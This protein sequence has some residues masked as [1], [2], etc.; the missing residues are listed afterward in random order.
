MQKTVFDAE[1]VVAARFGLSEPVHHA[2]VSDQTITVNGGNLPIRVYRPDNS[3]ASYPGI[4]YFHDGGWVMGN[5]ITYDASARAIAEQ[6]GAV[7]ISVDYRQ[8]PENKFPTAHNDAYAAYQWVIANAASFK[9]DPSR[10]AVAGE[11]AGANL[12]T[13]VCIRARDGGATMPRHQLLI[14]PIAQSDTTT[15]SYVQYAAAQPLSRAGVNWFFKHYL[16][17]PT[18]R[19]DT[20]I[21]LVNANLSGLPAATI[22]SA[23]IDP[24]RDDGLQLDSKL[25]AHGVSVDRYLYDGVTHDFFGLG[26]VVPEARDAQNKAVSA[27][28]Q[29]LQ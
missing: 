26:T 25:R 22:I 8:G 13:N 20:R 5:R 7:V 28:L 11:G 17:T 27:L 6:S 23:D 21:A 16:A 15:P 18:Q 2:D 19:T 9:I 4:I 12:A 1:R 10:L 3:L 24:L 14:Y 29:S